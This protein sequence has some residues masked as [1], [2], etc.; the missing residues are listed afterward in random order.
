MSLAWQENVCGDAKHPVCFTLVVVKYLMSENIH[1]AIC[2][3]QVHPSDSL[4]TIHEDRPVMWSDCAFCS[5]CVDFH[6]N[7]LLMLNV[8]LDLLQFDSGFQL[9][10]LPAFEIVTDKFNVTQESR[11]RKQKL[12]NCRSGSNR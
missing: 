5:K 7:Y 2:T 9:G 8:H 11:N 6:H 1:M 10:P 4:S 12:T 3:Y